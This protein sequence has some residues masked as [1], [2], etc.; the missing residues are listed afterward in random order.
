MEFFSPLANTEQK[1]FSELVMAYAG[2]TNPAASQLAFLLMRETS[3]I[4]T[5]GN[6]FRLQV[7]ETADNITIS[8]Q[9]EKVHVE[10]FT[11]TGQDESVEEFEKNRKRT[12]YKAAEELIKKMDAAINCS[13]CGDLI[14]CRAVLFDQNGT[15]FQ[16]NHVA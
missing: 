15:S 14:L 6:R 1:Y 4:F 11:N 5:R 7:L 8:C 10:E 3:L 16:S 2:P 13:A 12:Y 9:R